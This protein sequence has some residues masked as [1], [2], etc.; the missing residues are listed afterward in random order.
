MSIPISFGRSNDFT[1]YG[2]PSACC[3]SRFTYF[4][5]FLLTCTFSHLILINSRSFILNLR[6]V[7][8]ILYPL[9]PCSSPLLFF[10]LITSTNTSFPLV[11]RPVVQLSFPLYAS[12]PLS[13]TLNT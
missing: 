2:F 6:L 4:A 11:H 1:Q 7:P 12:F 10:P 3:S 5:F 8:R 13:L 9:L